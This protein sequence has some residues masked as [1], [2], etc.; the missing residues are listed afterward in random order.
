M[1]QN[2]VPPQPGQP[3]Q[4]PVQPVQPAQP[5]QPGQPA[6]HTV[7]PV[8]PV[9]PAQPVQPVQPTQSAQ[10]GYGQPVHPQGAPYGQPSPVQYAQP[11]PGYGAPVNPY[12]MPAGFKAP[13]ILITSAVLQFVIAGLGIIGSLVTLAAGSVAGKVEEL[14]YLGRESGVNTVVNLNSGLITFSAIISLATA[15]LAVIG[16]IFLLTGKGNLFTL[17][18]AG[19]VL[20]NVIIGFISLGAASLVGS[21]LTI[22]IWALIV[23]GAVLASS[24]EFIRARGGKVVFSL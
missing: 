10:P 8:Q 21:V 12:A 11:Q 24:T 2:P 13:G 14:S 20:L 23:V 22:G 4:P 17:I 5:M 3:V 9:Q 19:T 6:A 1:T 7:P 16:G 18:A 15:A